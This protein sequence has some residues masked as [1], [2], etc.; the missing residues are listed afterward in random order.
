MDALVRVYSEA[1][2]ETLRDQLLDA[3]YPDCKERD[4]VSSKACRRT[5]KRR[6]K[7]TKGSA[8]RAKE[9]NVKIA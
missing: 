5:N 2:N 6:K 1:A 9:D 4:L 3:A 7:D 8:K